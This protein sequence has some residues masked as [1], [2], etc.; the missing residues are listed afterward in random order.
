M[1]FSNHIYRIAQTLDSLDSTNRL[2]ELELTNLLL[3]TYLDYRQIDEHISNEQ[4]T[5][6]IQ[7]NLI[8]H[9]LATNILGQTSQSAE[10]SQ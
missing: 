5:A 1:C 8:R 2:S 10:R 7:R 9:Q 6:M 4:L 3:A